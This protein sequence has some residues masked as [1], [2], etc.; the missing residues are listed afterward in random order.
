M[1]DSRKQEKAFLIGVISD[2]R[3]K[4]EARESFDELVS[5]VDTA[6]PPGVGPTMIERRGIFPSTLFS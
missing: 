5:L 6:G 4:W 3:D 1:F 2:F